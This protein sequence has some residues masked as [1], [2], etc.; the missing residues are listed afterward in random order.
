MLSIFMV[1]FVYTVRSQFFALLNSGTLAK[2][3]PL[4]H[5]GVPFCH[6]CTAPHAL[7]PLLFSNSLRLAQ[8]PFPLAH[9]F[10]NENEGAE[11][12]GFIITPF[13]SALIS[14]RFL[15][16]MSHRTHAQPCVPPCITMAIQSSQDQLA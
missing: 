8:V 14:V 15:L 3:R 13:I 2:N 10:F 4:D 6:G 12:N 9:T 16:T 7:L 1:L 5:F 11:L